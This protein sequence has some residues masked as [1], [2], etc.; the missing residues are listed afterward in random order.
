MPAI[1]RRNDAVGEQKEATDRFK[2]NQ[3]R[4]F[5]LTDN[6]YI[7]VEGNA[8]A[9]FENR[10]P[11]SLT[12]GGTTWN[13]TTPF[14]LFPSFRIDLN[15]LPSNL[16]NWNLKINPSV[17]I[18]STDVY[19]FKDTQFTLDE[20]CTL[21]KVPISDRNSASEEAYKMGLLFLKLKSRLG[22]V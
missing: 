15:P 16:Q 19:T 11:K 18:V 8:E 17:D 10:G 6:F 20:L 22:L 7:N 4:Y 9:Y 5:D 12:I 3:L 2:N 21:Y 1:L 13:G 14:N